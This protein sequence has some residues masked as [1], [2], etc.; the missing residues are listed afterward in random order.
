MDSLRLLHH[1]LLKLSKSII[2]PCYIVLP[3]EI[4]SLRFRGWETRFPSTSPEILVTLFLIN[5]CQVRFSNFVTTSNCFNYS[6]LFVDEK[7]SVKLN[8]SIFLFWFPGT[9]YIVDS[10]EDDH[11]TYECIAENSLGT[12]YS[13]PTTLHVK[14]LF[15][16]L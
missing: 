15:D 13:Q 9:L 12:E 3:Q 6:Y 8:S 5:P 16:A 4:L 7:I 2:L 14:G 1:H 11:G 10:V